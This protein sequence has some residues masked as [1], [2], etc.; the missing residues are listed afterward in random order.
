VK[1]ETSMES[2][3]KVILYRDLCIKDYYIVDCDGVEI[4]PDSD[5]KLSLIKKLTLYLILR[6]MYSLLLFTLVIVLY[7]ILLEFSYSSLEVTIGDETLSYV[8]SISWLLILILTDLDFLMN[9]VKNYQK[10]SFHCSK[11]KVHALQSLR[12]Y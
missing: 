10:L 9:H 8:N 12:K 11:Q 7:L 2:I 1:P 6:R 5:T 3:K 4:S